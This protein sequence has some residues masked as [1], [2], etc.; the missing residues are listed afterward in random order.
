MQCSRI[1]IAPDSFKGSLAAPAVARALAT[2]IRHNAP[3]AEIIEAPMADGGEGTLD[4]VAVA[5]PGQR[6]PVNLTG[7]HG[8]SIA[9][10]WYWADDG[11]AY[12]ESAAALGLP[13]VADQH[14]APAIWQR[15]SAALGALIRDALDAG[16][17]SLVVGLGGSACNDAGLGML[18]E[19]G[20]V[21]RDAHG[22]Q[23]PADLSGLLRLESVETQ[24]LDPRLT[25]VRIRALCDVDNPLLG[26]TGAAY[27]YG[28]QK[29]LENGDLAPVDAAFA[30][31]AE[32]LNAADAENRPG[33][34]A[35]G[36]LG[37]ALAVLGA[38]LESGAE[39]L[40]RLTGLASTL[41][42][43]DWVITGEGRTDAQTLSGKTALAVA[44]AAD[45]TPTLLVSGQIVADLRPELAEY[46]TSCYSLAEHSGSVE[47]A[48]ADPEH[49]LA[50]IGQALVAMPC[51]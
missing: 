14:Q 35:A 45:P 2:G 33:A 17:Q 39:G 7:I 27:V 48:S 28:P 44:R 19:L 24:A 8:H 21:A 13:L 30:R 26:Q 50:A 31:F 32:A 23:V 38:D 15:S 42:R 41:T 4:C 20:L 16:C 22:E 43:A 11:T 36:G 40:L 10:D 1:V 6:R 12:I 46:F 34:G 18:T 51:R 5:C 47:G 3:A 29:G 49:W 9:A 37:F 25:G